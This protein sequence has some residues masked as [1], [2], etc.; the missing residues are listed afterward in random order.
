[1]GALRNQGNR[2]NPFKAMGPVTI[3]EIK[4]TATNRFGKKYTSIHI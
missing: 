4:I 3:K 2:S 1:M